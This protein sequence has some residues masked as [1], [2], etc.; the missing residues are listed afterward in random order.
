[1]RIPTD[2][3]TTWLGT[4]GTLPTEEELN[5]NELCFSK[6]WEKIEIENAFYLD[7]S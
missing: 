2:F 5:N 3:G 7:T 1:M 4:S 6:A